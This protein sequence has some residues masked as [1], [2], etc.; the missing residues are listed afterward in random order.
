MEK[1]FLDN[2]I[3]RLRSGRD[4]ARMELWQ[5]YEPHVVR[6]VRRYL[7][8][9]TAPSPMQ[10]RIQAVAEAVGDDLEDDDQFER[11]VAWSFCESLLEPAGGSE[12]VR[13][14]HRETLC[15]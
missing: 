12:V 10:Q 8:P 4:S 14:P 2:L 11:R 3:R 5:E 1:Y 9:G 15:A 7:R 6:M 13:L